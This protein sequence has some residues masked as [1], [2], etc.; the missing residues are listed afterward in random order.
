[1]KKNNFYLSATFLLV[2]GYFGLSAI[3]KTEEKKSPPKQPNVIIILADDLGYGDLSGYGQQNWSTPNIDRLGT[4][5]A[6]LTHFY[7]PTPYC[8]PT[9][10]SLLTGRYPVRNKITINPNPEKTK[11]FQT[12]RGNDDVG[13]ADSELLL[14]EAFKQSGYA[15]K[16]IGKWHLGHKPEFYPTRHGF[17]EYF[18][19]PYSNDMR[20]VILMENEKK[21][22]YPVVQTSLTQRYTKS[23]LEF[24][25]KNKD[26]PFFLYLPQAMPHKPLAVS[27]DFYTPSTK[28]DL[29]ADAMRELDWSVGEVLKKLQEN[30]LD[31][32]TIVIFLSDNGPW[33]GGSSGG[34]R[35]MKAQCWEGGIRVPFLIRWKGQIP[36]GQISH[37]PAGVIDVFPT[38]AKLTN[39]A[40]PKTLILDGKDILPLLTSKAKSPHDALFSFY[41]DKLQTV[42]SGKWKLHLLS[43]EPTEIPDSTWIDPRWPDGVTILA[44]YEQAKPTQFP[45]IKT[46]DKAAPLLLFDLEKDPSEQKNVASENPEI[47]KKLKA[48]AEAYRFE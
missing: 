3:T 24:I 25:D 47:V 27:E 35:G 46:G 30:N 31:E 44:P 48:K 6:K 11:N 32:N 16:I 38:L 37:E 40:L 36:A 14:S 29:Y 42:R 17:D 1:M 2:A 13:I 12:Y 43:P 22:E 34:L 4:E 5:G 19:I 33:F 45:G 8:A 26:K 10:A 23:A 15:T 21:V 41:T 7:T 39:L 18:G 20:P 28:A 9:R